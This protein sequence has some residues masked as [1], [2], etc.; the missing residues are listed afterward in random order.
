[1]IDKGPPTQRQIRWRINNVRIIV[2]TAR[3]AIMLL[4][5]GTRGVSAQTPVST[6]AAATGGQAAAETPA[7]QTEKVEGIGGMFFRAADPKA[8]ADW[9]ER[10]LGVT[11]TPAN[12]SE[13]PWLQQAGHTVF[14]PFATDTKYFGRPAQQWMI[15]FRVRNLDAMVSQLRTA[16]IVVTVDPETY[17]N[18]RFARLYDPEGN[19]IELWEVRRPAGDDPAR[20]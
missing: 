11:R 10:H 7:T 17:P 8:L 9:Y 1:M 3:A 18:G 20:P 15:N 13:L 12:Y 16:G 14:A 5:A 4:I 19:P 2:S 6:T